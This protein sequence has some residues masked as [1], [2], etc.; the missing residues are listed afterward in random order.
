MRDFVCFVEIGCVPVDL[1]RELGT[2]GDMPLV[3]NFVDCM[4]FGG[5]LGKNFGGDTVV[6]MP[7]VLN[8]VDCMY[9][10][11]DLGKNFG[12]ETVVD[13]PLVQNFVDCM[14]FGGDL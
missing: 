11:D 9:F 14:Y 13:M 12:G 1:R 7:L 6:D 10:G 5:D 8:F 4:C 3:Q 2:V